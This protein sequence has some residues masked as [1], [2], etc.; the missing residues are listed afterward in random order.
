MTGPGPTADPP[1]TPTFPAD[2]APHGY[3]RPEFA[4]E[5]C[6]RDFRRPR[7]LRMPD[8]ER[9]FLRE[10]TAAF[11]DADAPDAPHR[12]EEEASQPPGAAEEEP[13][14]PSVYHG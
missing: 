14:Q 11:G 1:T 4:P 3:D 2:A 8:E 13:P 9:R 10:V 5:E 6:G 7:K 12:L